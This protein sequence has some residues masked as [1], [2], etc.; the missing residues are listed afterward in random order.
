MIPELFSNNYPVKYHAVAIS[1]IDILN[2]EA[3]SASSPS[4]AF[5]VAV[6]DP[7]FKDGDWHNP[8][9]YR[10]VPYQTLRWSYFK[11]RSVEEMFLI[12]SL[13]AFSFIKHLNNGK[14]SAYSKSM[15]NAT[16]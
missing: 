8:D 15:K 5:G 1:L 16:I 10:D 13:D 6:K 11:N 9:T 14:E 7:V 2:K 12:V 4:N 3:N